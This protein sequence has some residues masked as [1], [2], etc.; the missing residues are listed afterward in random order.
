MLIA[1][2]IPRILA[3]LSP[4]PV[5]MDASFSALTTARTSGSA[6]AMRSPRLAHAIRTASASEIGRKER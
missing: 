3:L 6:V 5:A 1:N 2:A 4:A